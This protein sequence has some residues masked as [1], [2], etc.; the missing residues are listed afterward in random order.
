MCK[1]NPCQTFAAVSFGGDGQLISRR[2]LLMRDEISIDR[3]AAV[4]D[5]ELAEMI[6]PGITVVR[7]PTNELGHRAAKNL[8]ERMAEKRVQPSRK[9]VLAT[10]FIVRGSC[11]C[12]TGDRFG[13]I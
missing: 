11:G 13:L 9:I 12:G 3:L 5:F 1:P 6:P 10:E 4:G 2:K 8:F 7:Q